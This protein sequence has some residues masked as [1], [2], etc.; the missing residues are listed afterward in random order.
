MSETY[1]LIGDEYLSEDIWSTTEIKSGS[2]A[3]CESALER[4]TGPWGIFANGQYMNCKVVK[5][6]DVMKHMYT[7]EW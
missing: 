2:K 6:K 4:M 5:Q 1:V 7:Y 3:E